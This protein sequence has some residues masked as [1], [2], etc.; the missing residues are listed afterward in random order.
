[1]KSIILGALLASAVSYADA[2]LDAGVWS[3]STVIAQVAPPAPPAPVP[4]VP[5]VPPV[6]HGGGVNIN[7]HDGKVDISGIEEMVEE[8]LAT[9]KESIKTAPLDA[10]TK[11]KLLDKLDKVKSLAKKRLKNASGMTPEQIG[12]EMGRLGEEIGAEMEEFGGEMEKWGDKQ[13]KKAN[14]HA[15]VDRDDDDDDDDDARAPAIDTDDDDD[16]KQAIKDLGDVALKP[17]QRDAITKLRKD[18]DATVATAKKQ[19]DDLSAKLHDALANK[20]VSDADIARL[21]DQISA[22]ESVIRKA[23]LIA[24]ASARRVLDDAQ[25]KRVEDAAAKHKSK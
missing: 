15:H 5:P 14:R 4:P 13:A 11:K 20:A 1:M 25:R 12:E 17:A 21:V 22:Q 8:Q 10:A 16:M 18:S 3:T 6:R 23:R 2:G 9:A 19:L 7:I 24:W